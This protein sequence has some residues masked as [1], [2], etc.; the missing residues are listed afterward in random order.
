MATAALS[1]G[2]IAAPIRRILRRQRNV[3]RA[4]R[5]GARRSIR[6][7]RPCVLADGE[8]AYDYLIVATGATHSYFGHAEW[9][10]RAPG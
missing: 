4:A 1:P 10:R 7:D 5:R 3:E 6:R 2:D 9:G 8:L